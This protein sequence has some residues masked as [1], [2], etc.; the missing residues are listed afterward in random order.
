MRM[1]SQPTLGSSFAPPSSIA[2]GAD[3]YAV[4]TLV[5][6]ISTLIHRRKGNLFESPIFRIADLNIG[7]GSVSACVVDAFRRHCGQDAYVRVSGTEKDAA[8]LEQAREAL[9]ARNALGVLDVQDAASNPA[10]TLR[11]RLECGGG[12]DMVVYAHAAYPERL[13]GTRLPRM[14]NR[15]GD[16]VATRHGA[17]V[18]LHNHGASD[19]DVIREKMT[20]RRN[21]STAG[22]ICNT[23]HKLEQAFNDTHMHAFSIT[24]P[25]AVTLPANMRAVDAVLS[26]GEAALGGKDAADAAAMRD[27]LEKLSGGGKELDAALAAMGDDARQDLSAFFRRRIRQA[28]GKDMP[29]TV[30]GG[31]MVMAFHSAE[32]AQEAF[33]A[34]NIACREMSPPAIALPISRSVMPEFDKSGAHEEWK[35]KL[36]EHGIDPPR[37]CQ[38]ELDGGRE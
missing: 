14:V 28:G 26:R 34:V 6:A 18:T 11:N 17:V 33:K 35:G 36:A 24:V 27:M 13:S 30:G 5:G 16:M 23:Q 31:Q 2:L 37:V 25:N 1:D 4:S 32:L 38:T 3:Q 21:H 29:V 10:K 19:A 22:V 7:D 12:A 20:G 8:V 15:L 9:L